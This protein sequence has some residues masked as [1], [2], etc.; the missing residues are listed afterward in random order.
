MA[1][2]SR[3]AAWPPHSV[4]ERLARRHSSP[5]ARSPDLPR[6]DRLERVLVPRQDSALDVD[7]AHVLRELAASHREPEAAEED[8][9]RADEDGVRGADAIG[10]C[11]GEQ[12]AERL[13]AED[14]HRVE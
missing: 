3:A 12:A 2:R 13:R 9:D 11:A 14:G 6:V 4:S 1:A 8:E 5:A 10:D 7:R